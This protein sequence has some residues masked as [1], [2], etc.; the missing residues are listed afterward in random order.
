MR[1]SSPLQSRMLPRREP[2]VTGSPHIPILETGDLPSEEDW[3]LVESLRF[4]QNELRDID[5]DSDQVTQW[6]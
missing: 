3:A 6:A 1:S 2:P 5:P 4:D